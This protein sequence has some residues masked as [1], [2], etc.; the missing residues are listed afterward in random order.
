MF[1][2]RSDMMVRP[3]PSPWIAAVSFL[4]LLLAGTLLPAPDAFGA[5]RTSKADSVA[6]RDEGISVR[7]IEDGKVAS[8]TKT[9][10]TRVKGE[11]KADVPEP[12]DAPDAP[13]L[14]ESPDHS[15]DLVRFGQDIVIAADQ[16]VDGDVVAIG[17]NIEVLGRVKGSATAVGGSVSIRD[18]GVVEGDA[19]SVGGGTTTSDSASVSGSNV[20]VGS[21]PFHGHGAVLP[22][23]G[24]MGFGALAGILTTIIQFLL[25]ILFAWICLLLVRERLEHA[26]DRM[27]QSFGKSLLWGLVG[28]MA[29]LVAIPTLVVV[30][31]IA[32]VILVITIIGIPIAILLAIA[33]VFALI[34]TVLAIIVGT[35]LAYLNGAMYLG[36]RL[37]ARRS[38]G[39]VVTPLRAIIVGALVILGLKALGSILGLIGVVFVMPIGIA[40]GI[41]AGAL[42]LVFTT[43]GLGAMILTRFGKG[44]PGAYPAAP[45][46]AAPAAAPAA[47][48]WYAPPPP[49]SPPPP[50]QPSPE[51][52]SS[53]AP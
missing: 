43:A 40:L 13:D 18:K 38:P 32:M 15:N 39:V 19:V 44:I 28:W 27:G 10:T 16:V 50:P 33:M 30:C 46:V 35:F 48:G 21:W 6:S 5:S 29:M 3:L 8:V 53:D 52:G 37:L 34:A 36:R 2:C 17:G 49:P 26:V 24:V 1:A 9:R 22:L 47:Q 14:P 45:H 20:S 4:A 25:T 51:G 41:M 42:L 12:P 31:A 11:E 23:L 7:V